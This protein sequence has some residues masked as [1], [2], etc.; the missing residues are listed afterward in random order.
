[1]LTDQVKKQ[2]LQRYID[3]WN[4]GDAEGVLALFADEATAEDPVGTEVAVGI[5]AIRA[6][7][8]PGKEQ[9]IRITLDGPIRTTY[10]NRA[11][12]AFTLDCWFGEEAKRIKVI[13]VMTLDDEG[14]I[15]AL[16]AHWGDDDIEPLPADQ[17]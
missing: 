4:D 17:H 2:V 10:G 1:M 7:L 9:V 13:D 3:C 16:E 12:M 15:L 6:K 14:K 5:E 8:L 11:A